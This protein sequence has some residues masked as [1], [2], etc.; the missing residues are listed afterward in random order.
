MLREVICLYTG[1][2]TCSFTKS[3]LQVEEQD[4][5]GVLDV[6]VFVTQYFH[7]FDLRTTMLYIC[8]RHFR[9]ENGVFILV[10][11]YS[12]KGHL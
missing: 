9:M 3:D 8:E 4:D 1:G 10:E 6:H 12:A 2:D 5:K 7:K 11:E